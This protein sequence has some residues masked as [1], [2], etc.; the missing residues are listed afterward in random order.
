MDAHRPVSNFKPRWPTSP[1]SNFVPYGGDQPPNDPNEIPW[2]QR[3]G[4]WCRTVGAL[5]NKTHEVTDG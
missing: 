5:C 2:H 4:A 3:D 1:P